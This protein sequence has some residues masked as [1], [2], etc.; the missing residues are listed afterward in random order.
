MKK[1]FKRNIAIPSDHGS[2]V[3]I[4][5]PLIVGMSVGNGW[6]LHVF[7]FL[8][9]SLSAFMVRQPL[10]IAVK[11]RSGRRSQSDNPAALFWVSIYAVL[12]LILFGYLLI[13]GFFFILYLAVP[14]VAVFIWYLALIGKMA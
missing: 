4:L 13:E 14:G 10:S 3:F 1:L 12:I 11:I 9:L 7:A 8:F 5:M 2:W 6:N